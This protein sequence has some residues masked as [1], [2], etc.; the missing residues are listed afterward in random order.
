MISNLLTTEEEFKNCKG[1]GF[2][3]LKCN[4]CNLPFKRQKK[5]V[6][7]KNKINKPVK[8]CSDKCYKSVL[9]TSKNFKCTLCNK[10]FSRYPSQYNR[11]KNLFCSKTC[12][13]TYN[14]SHRK[15]GYTRSKLEIWIEKELVKLYPNL[16]ILFNKKNAINS[17][18]DIYI[19][20]IKLAFELNGIYHYEPIFGEKQ[21]IKARNNDNRKF[22]ACL[23]RGIELYI[24]DVSQQKRF[25]EKSSQPFLTI[26]CSV[27]DSKLHR[28]DN[29]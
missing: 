22:Q 9:K 10:D 5:I 8:F 28:T 25:T 20:S 14:N 17:E 12:A 24:I 4:Y 18:L 3:Y 11:S 21:L 2:V 19:P 13:A 29:S 27:I 6:V 7:Y 23:E 1:N 16:E 15:I 26:I